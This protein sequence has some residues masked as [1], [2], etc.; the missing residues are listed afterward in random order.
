MLERS[1]FAGALLLSFWAEGGAARPRDE[2]ARLIDQ[3]EFLIAGESRL[4]VYDWVG[5]AVDGARV[6][7]SG[8]VTR[9]SLRL[10]IERAVAKL[11]AVESVRNEIEEFPH[12]GDDIGM[13]VN[14]Y[15]RIYGHPEIRR[16]LSGETKFKSRL[17]R[18]QDDVQ[19]VLLQPVHILVRGGRI[20]LEGEVERLS[21][22]RTVEDQALQ[23]LGVRGVINNLIVTGADTRELKPI[24]FQADPWWTDAASVAEPV[25]RIENP[26]GGVR[27]RV[28]NSDRVRVR[29]S[30]AA[31]EVREDDTVT[32]QFRRKTRIRAQPADGELVDLDV[33]LPYGYRLEV[34]TADGPITL[35]G[36]V[37]QAALKTGTGALHVAVPWKT[38][39]LQTVSKYRP[40]HVD[41]PEF[42]RSTIAP[43]RE[44][45]GNAAWTLTDAH[46][47]SRPLYG[48][49]RIDA[50]RP[51]R[52]TL[53]EAEVDADAPVRMHWDAPLVLETVFR[54]PFERKL[55]RQG[56]GSAKAEPPPAGA[57]SEPLLFS[58]DV[59]LVDL[60]VSV[61]DA[62]NRPLLGL[63]PDDFKVIEDGVEQ[64][65]RIVQG[66][67]SPFNLVLL[68][69]CSTSTLIDRESIVEAAR[70]FTL[71]ARRADRV[72]VYVL[73]DSYLHVLATLTGDHDAVLRK[74]ENIPQL[75]GGTPLYDAVVLSYAHELA[76]QR[77]QRNAL[78]VISDGMDNDLLPN[79]NR[80]VPSEV[81][82]E[83]LERA[84][85]EMNAVIYPIFLEPEP[86]GVRTGRSWR[87]RSRRVANR[88]RDRLTRIAAASGGRL[89]SAESIGDLSPVYEAVAD[90]LRSVYTL[91][92][93]PSNQQFDGAWRRIRVS[94]GRADARVRTRPG[95]Y[96]R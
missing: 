56:G 39:R 76:K 78:I 16:Y 67:E 25:L 10:S 40:E 89:F 64:D 90:E 85:A 18:S 58:S 17:R 79:W 62:E 70:R 72:A 36:M 51:A 31:R 34:E 38:T 74:I 69:D 86:P 48:N 83:E 12:S 42:L 29:R 68:L 46:P 63:S 75:S 3:I 14:A 80:S 50:N 28:T 87:E 20:T 32:T 96:G 26:S 5:F 19:R 49:I 88:A 65:I 35:E 23:V 9:P 95:Y 57:A 22:K 24:D 30:A 11:E 7:L 71:A 55:I 54:S 43:H 27:V 44:I 84:A 13:R 6:T 77:W 82:A 1:I 8:I 91:G 4:R 61:V 2:A 33:D 47:H 92:Y 94:V 66:A 52:L 93:Y 81:S 15:W 37:R 73:A 45:P 60:T 21:D 53:R 59:R 41:L